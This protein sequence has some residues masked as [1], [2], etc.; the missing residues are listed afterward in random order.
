MAGFAT[1]KP[2]CPV[3]IALDRRTGCYGGLNADLNIPPRNWL[4]VSH[5]KESPE[6]IKISGPFLKPTSH[7]GGIYNRNQKEAATLRT[8]K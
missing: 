5:R 3:S 8:L 7:F 4:G 1:R 6:K 2:F